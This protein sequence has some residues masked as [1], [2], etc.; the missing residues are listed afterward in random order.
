M[1][2]F[3][4]WRSI[5]LPRSGFERYTHSGWAH[6]IMSRYDF[7]AL[8]FSLLAVVASALVTQGVFE[9]FPISRMRLPT[10]GRPSWLRLGS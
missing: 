5:Y 2:F 6:G 1:G 8:I 7:L 9:A 3:T 10:Y 4:L